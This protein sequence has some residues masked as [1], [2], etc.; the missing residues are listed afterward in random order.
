MGQ[1]LHSL[2]QSV[3]FSRCL[4][5]MNWEALA[6]FTLSPSECLQF[7]TWWA[8]K[9]TNQAHRNAEAQTPV[10]ITSDQLL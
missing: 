6:Q 2:L 7:E 9:A 10:N 3:T 1:I 5:P 4:I 8:D